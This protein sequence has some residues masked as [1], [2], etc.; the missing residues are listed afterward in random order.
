MRVICKRPG[1]MPELIDIENEEQVSEVL[2]CQPSMLKIMR[3]VVL[4]CDSQWQEKELP[5]NTI[6]CGAELGG[7]I[8]MAGITEDGCI[9][10]VPNVDGVLYTYFLAV[11]YGRADRANNVWN[12]RRCGHLERFE[13][14]GPYENGWNVCPV[15]GGWLL[16]PQEL[17]EAGAADGGR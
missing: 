9:T 15:C 6:L 12:C 3:D 11:R 8:L 14:D 5:R 17:T 1:Q 4:I 7:T 13:A 10:D 2:G 16:R